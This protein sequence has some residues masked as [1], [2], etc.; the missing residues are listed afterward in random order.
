M[1]TKFIRKYCFLC[2]R[3]HVAYKMPSFVR[4]LA[5]KRIYLCWS[6]CAIVKEKLQQFDFSLPP[7][8]IALLAKATFYIPE[9]KKLQESVQ[10]D[11]PL[12][13]QSVPLA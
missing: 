12:C 9:K 8:K 4:V 13:R 11:K 3:K 10:M 6:C 7:D 2:N 5:P 1:A